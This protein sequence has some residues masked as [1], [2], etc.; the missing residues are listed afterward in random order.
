M[1]IRL[2]TS[3]GRG[4]DNYQET[5]ITNSHITWHRHLVKKYRKAIPRTI[6]SP[7]YNCHGLTFGSRR[8]K[9]DKPTHIQRI[10][11]DDEYKPVEMKDVLPG[12][13]VIYYSEAGDPNHSGIV[14]EYSERLVVPMIYSKWGNAGEFVHALRDCPT[15]YGP[16]FMFFRCMR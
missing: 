11:D 12:D 15:I 13:I 8:T 5:Q 1:A 7:T 3:K 9:I 4:I 16:D 14:L 6:Q 10:L 2:E